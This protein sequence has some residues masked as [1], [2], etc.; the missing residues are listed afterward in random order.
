MR[1]N[2]TSRVPVLEERNDDLEVALDRMFD[3]GQRFIGRYK[4]QGAV[5]RRQGG[6]GVVQFAEASTGKQVAL[7]A[8]AC[9]RLA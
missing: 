8:G 7:K 9:F 4:L 3:A 2:A 1:Y 5:A 6:Q